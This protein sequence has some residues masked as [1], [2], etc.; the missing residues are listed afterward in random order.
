MIRMRILVEISD[1]AVLSLKS[2]EGCTLIFEMAFVE[3][4]DSE[5]TALEN[6][7]IRATT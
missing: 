3:Y 7:Q 2:L 6:G 4:L 5:L 1:D